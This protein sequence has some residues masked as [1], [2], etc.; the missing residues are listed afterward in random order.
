MKF[1][2]LFIQRPI[3]S[4]TFSILIFLTGLAALSSLEV[5]QYPKI[6]SAT[7]VVSTGYPGAAQ[8]VMQGFVTT[9][10]AQAISSANG[11]EY[12]TST[13]TLGLSEIKAKLVL[14][15]DA[16][17]A[18]T[19]ILAKVQQVKYRLP[20]GTSD[21]E[22]KKMTDGVSAVQYINFSSDNQSISEITDYVDRVAK[23]LISS[24]KGVASADINGGQTYAMRL[25]V[26]PIKLA[27]RGLTA[28]DVSSA[29]RENNVQAAPGALR[30]T[31]TLVPITAI[32]DL[33]SVGDFESMIIKR[34]DNSVVRLGDIA[35]VELGSQNYDSSFLGDGKRVVSIAISPTPDG[36]PLEIV[37][38]VNK[39]LPDLQ[40]AAPP[41]MTITNIFDRA[42]FVNASIDEV[43]K[44]LIEAVI[45]V[46]IVIFLFLGS[47]R[48][49]IIP[50]ATIPLSL[51]GTAT[52][53]LMFG[54]SINL[55]TLLAM[56]LAIGLVVDDAIVVVEN[57]H[58]HIEE[59]LSPVRASLVGA[60]EI[61]WP[62]IGMTITLA[63]VYAPIGLM[64]G[65]TG[66]LF[67]EFA[68]TLA[69]AVIVSGVVAL[70][71]SPMMSSYLLN[72][73]VSEGKLTLLIEGA[74]HKLSEGYGNIL[75]KV[76]HA[77]SSVILVSI[78][79]LV[80]IVVLFLGVKN[81]LAP[82]EDQGYVYVQTK[83]PQ[84]ANI[85]Y[86]EK[87]AQEVIGIFKQMPVYQNSF[88][89]NGIHGQN[90][91]FGGIVLTPWEERKMS[92]NE[93]QDIING[94]AG[95]VIRAAATAFQPAPLPAGSDGLPVQM[96]LRAPVEFEELYAAL[97]QIKKASW[98][99]GLFAYVE[100][101]LAFDMPQ[102][103]ITVNSSKAG[104]MGVAMKD[105]ADTLATL[106]GENYVN[107]FNW[108]D[109]SYD[110]IFQVPQENRQAPDDL[111]GYY[112]RSQSG[113]LVPL[114]TLVDVEMRP[115][116]NRL[117]QF[118]QMNA[119]TL[120][121]VLMPGVTMGQ[122]VDFLKSQPL[123][124]GTKIDWLSDSRQFIKEGNR[125]V[126]S[127]G[128]ALIVIFLVLAAQYESF[129]D[130]LV[131]LITVPLA[132][133]GALMP[134][135]LGYTTMNIYSQIGLVTLIG[136][137]SKHGILMVSFANDIQHSEGLSPLKAM[138]KAAVIRMR[139]VLMTTAA[140]VAGLVPLLFAAGAGAESRFA[141]GIVVVTGM[142][143]GTA[144]TLFVLPSMY[145][146]IAKD[147]R[148]VAESERAKELAK[149]GGQ[150]V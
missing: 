54:F 88:F 85:D 101:N 132:I 138:H 111:T 96:V 3:L 11:I 87:A 84:Y 29:L 80:G 4:V 82:S 65:L 24:V 12:L 109:R 69:C 150:Y 18:M 14:N 21:P 116:P 15:A 62:V 144:F 26:D 48:S 77:R 63:A 114:A 22:I 70:T 83:S 139:P 67:K 93:V 90:N 52:L 102:A 50:I 75:G 110:V 53:M 43:T 20:E 106:V 9:P 98:G 125:L 60:R 128:F 81:E 66:A 103:R 120:S 51:V 105:V 91:G 137:I 74:M 46:V 23:P 89:V 57:I 41:G 78:V 25:W 19:E 61:V 79:V 76:L 123:P 44:T 72:K 95:K 97:E 39:L 149:D 86:T 30:A 58:R 16:D 148:V 32:T 1:T 45:I 136:L 124:N 113:E 17:R 6:E 119:V 134:I 73:N 145:T 108:F 2:D 10:I 40:D 118:N 129:R 92:S 27:S 146:M 59:G 115:A 112:V 126:L 117:P 35:T 42:R 8:E 71:L 34:S 107:R 99:S 13:S 104:E 122:G 100:S 68:F 130:P 94:Q 143:V 127:F 47:L 36:N 38:G 33:R 64:G 133:C 56:V 31:D 142:V 49:V 131:I 7:I 147:H 55:L 140:M 37:D 141:I 28:S 135:W 121:A 5:R